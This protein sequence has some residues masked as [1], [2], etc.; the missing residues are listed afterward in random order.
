MSSE[1]EKEARQRFQEAFAAQMAGELDRAIELYLGSIELFPTAEAYTFLGWTYHFQG[2][3]EAAIAECKRAI[4]IDP[5]FGNPY[6]DIGV[7]LIDLN[8]HDEAIPWL[9]Q[10]MKAKRYDP[11]H[12][13]YYNL[14]RVYLHKGLINRA[15]ELFQES[16]TIEPRYALARAGL[17]SA[18]RMLN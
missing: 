2:K 9:E 3:I 5:D 11:R 8:R 6:N 14:G 4:K 16:L 17:E 12:F 7:Y 10:A 18:R 15:R 1:R 13:P